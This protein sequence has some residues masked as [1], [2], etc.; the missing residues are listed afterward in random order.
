[1]T[2]ALAI[3]LGLIASCLIV[4]LSFVR[5]QRRIALVSMALSTVL[6]G[7]YLSLSQPVA[8][9][10]SAMSLGYAALVYFT[11]ARTDAFSLWVNGS[12]ARIILLGVYTGVFAVLN[13]GIGLNL[14][15]LA[16][17]GSVLMVAVMM[18][19]HPW[20]SKAILLVAGV[21]WTIFQYETGAYGNLVGQLF[22]FG[23]LVWSSLKLFQLQRGRVLREEVPEAA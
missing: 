9:T 19:E 7:Q 2:A 16:Y 21:C 17:L 15:L 22:Y 1:M 14:Q 18:V 11:V 13:G 10:L 23:G 8:A 12:S 4:A 6:V 20:L 3:I 5:G